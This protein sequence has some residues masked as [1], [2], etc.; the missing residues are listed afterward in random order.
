MRV[1]MIA[2]A[3][4]TIVKDEELLAPV[5]CVWRVLYVILKY[6]LKK[7]SSVQKLIIDFEI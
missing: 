5:T 4:W 6:C 7:Y 1:D 2:L 3:S